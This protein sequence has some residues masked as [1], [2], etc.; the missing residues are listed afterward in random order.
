MADEKIYRVSEINLICKATLESRF[1]DVWIEGEVSN[2]SRPQ[3]GH[4]YFTLKDDKAQ[5]RAVQFRQDKQALDFEIKDGVK[6]H[7]MGTVSIYSAS[8]SYQ[9]IC[10]RI[11]LAGK[12]SLQEAFEKL[13]KKLSEEGLFDSDK[14]LRIPL[15]PQHI[16]LVTS[17]TGAAVRDII[18]VTRRRYP[19]LHILIAPVLVQGDDAGR[20]IAH[21]VDYFNHRGD[22][23]VIIVARGGGSMEDLWAFNE[24][25]V[26]RAIA[27]SRI[28]IISG[29]GHETDF[30]ISD[31]VADLRAPTPSAAAEIV[32]G[33]KIEFERMLEGHQRHMTHAFKSVYLEKKNRFASASSSYVFRE[34]RNLLRIYRQRIDNLLERAK[35]AAVAGIRAC[36]QKVDESQMIIDNRIERRLDASRSKLQTLRIHISALDPHRVLQRG[37]TI[38]R[39]AS[40]GRTLRSAADVQPGSLLLTQ[41]QDGFI[42]S[43]AEQVEG[44]QDEER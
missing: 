37:Y 4:I 38:T 7:A 32:V 27:R 43:K 42:K 5:L 21:A 1:R 23:D 10:S 9:L 36:Q 29:V 19:N 8:G 18:N 26:A 24:E 40:S 16:G 22:V 20:Q 12:G 15:L 11:K 30:T 2:L 44:V 3:S 33:R 34:P 25:I 39:D 6:V 17:P 28:P 13:K 14:K 31:F 35:S 41:V